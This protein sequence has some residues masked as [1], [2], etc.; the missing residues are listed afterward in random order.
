[1]FVCGETYKGNQVRMQEEKKKSKQIF[2]DSNLCILIISTHIAKSKI[3]ATPFDNNRNLQ[4]S[5]TSKS[6]HFLCKKFI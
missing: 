2:K 1:M 4:S 6:L 5:S 3:R